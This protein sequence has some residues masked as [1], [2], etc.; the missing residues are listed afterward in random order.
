[1]NVI[2]SCGETAAATRG[3]PNEEQVDLDGRAIKAKM[4]DAEVA[5]KRDAD[6][7]IM[8]NVAS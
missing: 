5:E 1:V 2:N 4:G 8:G 3:G 7:Q 6:Q